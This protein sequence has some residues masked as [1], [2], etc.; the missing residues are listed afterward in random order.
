VLLAW[1]KLT[2]GEHLYLHCAQ[3]PDV[4]NFAKIGHSAPFADRV[5]EAYV[6]R[7]ILGAV[8]RWEYNSNGV[9]MRIL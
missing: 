7:M 3:I 8:D 1:L 5:K 9:T 6:G 4:K 2:E